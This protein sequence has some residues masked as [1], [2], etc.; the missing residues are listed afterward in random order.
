MKN[1]TLKSILSSILVISL[2]I[3]LIAGSTFALFTS[4]SGVNIA[5]NAGKV[6]MTASVDNI[7][8]YSVEAAEDGTEVD[9]NGAKYTYKKQ[10]GSFINGG[11]AKFDAENAT[12]E[13]SKVTPG[14]K[15]T[16]DIT[17]A[18]ESD[19]T[20][21]YRYVIKCAEGFDL[22]S[23]MVITIN[24]EEHKS[25]ASYTSKWE[26]LEAE[27]D[28]EKV[29]VSI[30]LP[31]SAG[32]VY[33][34]LSTSIT[35]TVEAV[36]GNAKVD[37][38]NADVVYFSSWDGTADNEGLAENTDE[39]EKKVVIESAEQLK[40]FAD[41]VNAGNTYKGYTV[42]LASDIHLNNKLWTPIGANADNAKKF[43]GTFDGQG[44]TIYE[45]Y[46]NQGAGYHAA[47][48]FGA[49]NGT[50][51]NLVIDGANISNIST[52]AASDNGTAVVAGSLY[53][54]GTID[55]VTV[56][57]ASV[58]A[59]RY[60]AGI[61]GYNYGNVTN[62]TVEN[63]VLTAY[64]DI[65]NGEADNGDKVGGIVGYMAGE[66]VY[67]LNNNTVKNAT[68]SGARDIG[69]VAGVVTGVKEMKNNTVS[70]ATITYS[71]DKDYD[72]A[73]AIVSQRIA[74][75]V[76]ESNTATNVTITK[77]D[78]TPVIVTTSDELDAAIKDGATTI[79]L[80]SGTYNIPASAKGKTLTIIGTKDSI[81]E[82]VPAGQGEADGQL[83]YNFDG[84]NVTFNGVTIKTN[85]QTYAGYARLS[86]TYNNCTF[87]NHY[88]LQRDSV[89]NNCVFNISG[90]QYNIWTWGAPNATFNGCT[91]N[92]DGKALLLYGTANTN[93]TVNDCT[94]ND[95]GGLTDLKAAIEI[96]NDYNK[97]YTLT[98]NNTTVN[99]YEINDKGIATG[100][101]LWAN[102]NSMSTENLNVVIDGVDVY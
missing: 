68:I 70:N 31:V 95:N 28:M 38:E 90:D 97:S 98:V 93:L 100:T 53:T 99:G 78:S 46:V 27:T 47:G 29:T 22:M 102:K 64:M 65:L 20:I 72:A 49:L 9:E 63:V 79:A 101:T 16:F 92:S 43:Q 34:G 80:G 44:H 35:V 26:K 15:V 86:A 18:N 48:L 10:D 57:N 50:V 88:S 56:K 17:G 94:F 14:D 89:F 60:V 12:F 87:E 73:G 23:G 59:N 71:I 61:A 32:N 19:V 74:I 13:L 2:C 91:F 33:Q 84:S 67:V 66:N 5:V 1:N 45:L 30:E 85:N 21:Q 51:K 36:Q 11:T 82:V 6:K 58:T 8:L 69:G 25:L 81:I 77:V 39:T 7:N 3:S 83:D 52:G 96:G 54:S 37:G 42:T 62:C 55:N 41:A 24:G 76:D 75:A 4:E 40:A